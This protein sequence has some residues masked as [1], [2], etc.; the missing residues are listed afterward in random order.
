MKA[1]LS[2]HDWE[3]LVQVIRR[4]MK[5]SSYKELCDVLLHMLN[6]IIPFSSGII[7]QSSRA[8]GIAKLDKPVIYHMTDVDPVLSEYLASNYPKFNTAIMSSK[9]I[10]YRQ[11]DV[12]ADS[13]A[14]MNSDIYQSL[15]KK[16]NCHY[17]LVISLVSNDIPLCVVSL[18]RS[19]EESDFTTRDIY[20]LEVL[21]QTM[22]EKFYDILYNK[23]IFSSSYYSLPTLNEAFGKKFCLTN[24]ENEILWA[25]ICNTPRIKICEALNISSSTLNKH[26]SNIYSKLNVS[27][28][29]EIRELYASFPPE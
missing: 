15:W 12:I 13:E 4:I 10:I 19:K 8:N 16:T 25:L 22:E 26:I 23:G 17:Q 1:T 9:T 24:R 11:S 21:S 20:I 2:N 29:L 18:F 14:W 3:Y 6:V 5:S 7:Y 27:S 28:V